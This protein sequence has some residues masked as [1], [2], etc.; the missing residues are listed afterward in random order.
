M[1]A[2]FVDKSDLAYNLELIR[3]TAGD[4]P[5]WAVLK[6]DGY[7]LGVEP[8]AVL[9]RQSG[10]YR[11]AVTEVREAAAIRNSG[12]GDMILMLR[13]T[14]DEEELKA[15]LGMDVICTVAS[16]QD[17]VVLAG[18]AADLGVRAKAHLKIDTGMGRYGF[19]PD[20]LDEI[21]ACYDHLDAIEILGLYT[22]FACAFCDEKKTRQQAAALQAVAEAVTKAGHRPGEIHCCNS[23]GLFRY[24]ELAAGGVR[25]GSAIVGR[26]G[27]KTELK[28]IGCCRASLEEVRWLNKGEST[29]YGAG[30]RAK[31]PTKI[32]VLP[33]GWYHGYTVEYGDDLFRRRDSLRGIFKNLKNLLLPPKLT[34]RVGKNTCRVLG[35]VGM[36]HTVIDITGT[37]LREGDLAEVPISP[38]LLRGMDV[39]FVE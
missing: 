29:G 16:Q 9:C 32:A 6:G 36:L 27:C 23:N 7:G 12:E 3:R 19:K 15:L 4:A 20:E 22:H 39:R 2:Y 14:C 17:A 18:V 24:P 8:M 5:V 13:P 1:K 26:L 37:E 10:W 21:L 38:V 33:V 11:F 35:H 28:R 25:V 30:W 34:V 31:K